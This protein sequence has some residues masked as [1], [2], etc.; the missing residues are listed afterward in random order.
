MLDLTLATEFIPGT[1]LKGAV[2]GGNWT[3]VLPRLDLSRVVAI[4]VPTA[5]TLATL[6][7]VASHVVIACRSRNQFEIALEVVRRRGL[8]N[9]R[10]H[11]LARSQAWEIDDRSTDLVFL[12]NRLEVLRFAFSGRIRIATKRWLKPNGQLYFEMPNWLYRF[13]S[14]SIRGRGASKFE[15]A[16]EQWLTPL[17]GESHTFIP[18][19]D[20]STTRF[21]LQKHLVSS[22]LRS[23]TLKN[24]QTRITDKQDG[25]SIE[26][27][28]GTGQSNTSR[29]ER[30][31]GRLIKIKTLARKTVHAVVRACNTCEQ[32]F[33]R[34]DEL[35]RWFGRL[36]VLYGRSSEGLSQGPPQYLKDVARESDVVIDNYRWG[37][38]ASG[39][40]ESRKIVFFLFA[41]NQDSPKYVVKMTRAEKFN[42]RLNREQLAL[43][44]LE[45]K[46]IGD[47]QTLPRVA[48]SG[49][50]GGLAIVGETAIDGIPFD[51]R[52]TAT[53]ACPYA[54]AAVNWL[55][56]L[57]SSTISPLGAEPSDIATGLQQL[58]ERF[59]DLYRIT[60]DEKAFLQAQI[61]VI[62]FNRVP[63][64]FQH[65]DPGRWNVLVTPN[66]R[67][68]FLDWEAA[69]PNG[70]PLWDLLYFL[71]SFCIC[72]GQAQRHSHGLRSLDELFLT[73]SSVSELAVESI[74]NYCMDTGLASNVVEPLFYTCWMHRALKESTRLPPKKLGS[75]HYFNFLRMC[76]EKRESPVLRRLF[77]LP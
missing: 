40:Y 65:G 18:S 9:V 64:V 27:S 38:S 61:S 52:T 71:R 16:Q 24:L 2:A 67:I 46:G 22:S 20:Q 69:E 48:F 17:S 5:A 62:G 8:T 36:G 34:P 68:S 56:E 14:R 42:G 1:N 35:G 33:N 44:L 3:F 54:R 49:T 19:T 30:G 31:G 45:E 55:T 43:Q 75:G 23:D 15:A 70:L 74:S 66:G 11:M 59:A 6:S 41:P 39:D 77:A 13:S 29:T 50:H 7:R 12:A 32:Q 57:G 51:R 26:K 37:L 72:V 28:R 58:L 63:L 53:S 25:R 4:G 76:M 47:S 60:A 10:P 21:F 73:D